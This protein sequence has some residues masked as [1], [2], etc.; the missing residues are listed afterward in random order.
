[1]VKIAFLLLGLYTSFTRNSDIWWIYVSPKYS[2]GKSSQY[3]N[4]GGERRESGGQ[5]DIQMSLFR[6]VFLVMIP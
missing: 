4:T 3:S 1:M 6:C 2:T 5:A